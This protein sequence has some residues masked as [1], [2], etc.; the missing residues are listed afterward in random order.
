M[1]LVVIASQQEPEVEA[2]LPE[3]V[4]LPEAVRVFSDPPGASVYKDGTFLGTTPIDLT[5]PDGSPWI[6]TLTSPG[7]QEQTVEVPPGIGSRRVQLRA[8]PEATPTQA[9]PRASTPSPSRAVRSAP[10]PAPTEP[11]PAAAAPPDPTPAAPPKAEP[12]SPEEPSR[13][14]DTRD[15]WGG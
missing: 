2:E 12:A 1:V 8:V 9:P 15:P 4:E 5:V 13:I 14:K 3:L 10:P 6:V 7:H 11:P